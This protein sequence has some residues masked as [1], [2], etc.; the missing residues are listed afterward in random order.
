[1]YNE[2]GT[3]VT[4]G[5]LIRGTGHLV[6]TTEVCFTTARGEGHGACVS[7]SESVEPIGGAFREMDHPHGR[8]T[9]CFV[10]VCRRV[11]RGS[12]VRGGNFRNGISRECVL[13]RANNVALQ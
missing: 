12:K 8:R 3:M 10:E 1:M 9:C 4:G 2:Q 13:A 7:N 5:S 6:E 11:R